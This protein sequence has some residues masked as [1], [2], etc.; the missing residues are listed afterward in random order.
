MGR[1]SL[2]LIIGLSFV[3][4]YWGLN[5]SRVSKD[6]LDNYLNY[7]EETVAHNVAASG[8]NIGANMVF[9]DPTWRGGY[10][11]LPLSGGTLS[12]SVSDIGGG[13]IRLL[14]WSSYQGLNDTV[15]VIMQP[16]SFSKYAYYTVNEGAVYWI[17]GDTVW[18]PMHTE[19]KLNISGSPVFYGKVTAKNGTNP[20]KS[21]AK[22]YGGYQSGVSV[23]IPPASLTPLTNAANDSGI[24]FN[25]T[26]LWL[27]FNADGTVSFRTTA[28]GTDS[29]VALSTFSPGG[30]ILVNKG[31]IH[32][33]GTLN[34]KVTIAALSNGSGSTNGN[35]WIDDDI[36]YNK[37]PRIDPSSNDYLG[38]VSENNVEITDNTPNRSDVNIMAS[39]FAEKGSFTAENYN[40][41]PPSGTIYLLGGVTQN[42]RGPVGQFSGST[43]VNGFRKNYKYDN[44]FLGGGTA[45]AFPL[46]G[47][48]EVLSWKE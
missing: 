48:Y 8:A 47:Q 3:F 45:P 29:T 20:K 11:N 15:T 30:V 5:F 37:D 41:R 17:T 21:A 4:L 39:V 19:S 27:T 10:S 23:P 16:S 28:G 43:V 34:G 26:D 31:D 7:Y 2:Y 36:V 42:T 9:E 40:T 18:G 46:T 33:K 6:A 38:I 44:R 14:A 12:V 32:V 35:V 1:N 25:N 13:K 24:V 22:F